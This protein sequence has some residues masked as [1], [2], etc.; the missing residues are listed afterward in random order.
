MEENSKKL[1]IFT[2][3]IYIITVIIRG[4]LTCF[5]RSAIVEAD[6]II[7]LDIANSL[8]YENRILIRNLDWGPKAFIYS[9]IISPFMLIKNPFIRLNLIGIFNSAIMISAV[10]PLYILGNKLFKNKDWVYLL[11]ILVIVLPDTALTMTFMTEVLFFPVCMWLFLTVYLFIDNRYNK[12][13][14]LLSIFLG[15]ECIILYFIKNVSLYFI[16]SI[17]CMLLLI[18]FVEKEKKKHIVNILIFLISCI[19]FYLIINNVIIQEILKSGTSNIY[20]NSIFDQLFKILAGGSKY[21]VFFIYCILF[22]LFGGLL[23]FGFFP[24]L[25]PGLYYKCYKREIQYFYFFAIISFLVVVGVISY[26]ISSIEDYGRLGIRL[27]LRYYFPLLMLF[28]MLMIKGVFEKENEFTIKRHSV[29][30]GCICA[31][32]WVVFKFFP[33]GLVDCLLL[34]YID[35]F[36]KL[37]MRTDIVIEQFQLSI[38]EIIFKIIIIAT[39]SILTYCLGNKKYFKK[40]MLIFLA[41]FI[42]LSLYNNISIT[43]KYR[44]V[45]AAYTSKEL[46]EESR[47]IDNY[48][49]KQDGNVL[50]I[51][52]G[53]NKTLDTF[54]TRSVYVTSK[55]SV[56]DLLDENGSINLNEKEIIS[57]YPSIPYEGL[58]NIS[59]IITDKSIK[60][61][62]AEQV[63]LD[64]VREFIVYKNRDSSKLFATV[65]NVEN[66]FPL[67]VGQTNI[68]NAKDGVLLTLGKKKDNYFESLEDEETLVYGPYMPLKAGNYIF[69]FNIDTSKVEESKE[70]LGYVDIFL[71]AD[72]S[73]VC[74]KDFYTG[75]SKVSLELDLKND[76]ESIEMR[77]FTNKAYVKFFNVEVKKIED[78]SK[79]D[80]IKR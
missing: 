43:V 58:H 71:N 75:D 50:V 47:I 49:W 25:Y 76:C 32:F 65:E 16:I 9:L 39:I 36:R 20:G 78:S 67:N 70:S 14:F 64:G 30:W 27:H 18:F 41:G 77:M 34:E 57:N 73:S 52:N 29:F 3:V 37:A 2:I 48:L 35:V 46:I 40:A 4:L 19:F 23:A 5:T 13:S 55:D 21:I 10:F 28:I 8:A 12:K 63:K 68:F 74:K 33:W 26:M 79:K 62:E 69:T 22:N 66:V 44:E 17:I 54:L 53:F 31:A 1:L 38:M 80:D 56:L 6:E 61:T 42:L 59:Y 7:Y 72:S 60:V 45:Y 15:L 24:V 51:T 11:L